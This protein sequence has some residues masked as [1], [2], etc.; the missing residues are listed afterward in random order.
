MSWL[1]A[2]MG[3]GAEAGSTPQAE[4]GEGQARLLAFC[5]VLSRLVPSCGRVLS[6]PNPNLRGDICEVWGP[7][8]PA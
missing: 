3:G 8:V 4:P 5:A 7:F 1:E 2:K 6:R